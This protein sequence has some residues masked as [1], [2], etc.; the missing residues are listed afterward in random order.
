MTLRSLL[1][2][3]GDSPAKMEKA[4]R[5]GADAIIL[6]LEDSVAESAK[7]DAR[8]AVAA[9]LAA[10]APGAGPEI[11]VRINPLSTPL[12]LA[13]LAAVVA[14]APDGVMLPK[15]EDAS[16]V[17]ALD[18]YLSALEAAAGLTIGKI[19]ILPIATETARAMFTLH[20]YVGASA[21]LGGLTWGA[22]DLPAAVGAAANREADGRYTPPYELARSLCLF[23]AA[24]AEVEA[25]DTVYPAF[26]DLEGLAAYAGRARRDGFS[27]MM[28]IHP[29]QVAVINAAFTPTAAEVAHAHR[30]VAAFDAAPDAGTVG[31]DGRMID[32]PHLKQARRILALD[33]LEAERAARA[34]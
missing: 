11:W 33:R 23:A 20:S 24:A 17:I 22:E 4:R 32:I 12:A 9:V 14:G 18:H 7:L 21:R 30:I 29:A 31:L 3:P 6:D 27:G 15:P 28:A 13:D 26:R 34:D 2:A 25:I 16:A 10:R 5:A 19:R 1:F 8:R